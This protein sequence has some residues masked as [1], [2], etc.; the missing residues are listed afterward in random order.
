MTEPQLTCAKGLS[1]WLLGYP[2]ICATITTVNS[3]IFSSLRG[4]P[5]TLRLS[6][7]GSLV[8]PC[9]PPGNHH[10]TVCFYSFPCSGLSYKW[11]PRV[12]SSPQLLSL[13]RTFSGFTCV[14]DPSLL[15]SFLWLHEIPWCEYTAL[16][17]SVKGHRGHFHLLGTSNSAA[18]NVHVHMPGWVYV[19]ISLRLTPGS[20]VAAGCWSRSMLPF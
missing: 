5:L 1:R 14:V 18:A 13:N 17:S 11:N 10:T 15:H 16:S 12:W 19:L 9:L 2:Q 7:T 20:R 6:P 8:R 3:G 4:N